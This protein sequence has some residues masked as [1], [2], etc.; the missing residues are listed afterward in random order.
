MQDIAIMSRELNPYCA[1]LRW[2]MNERIFGVDHLVSC[3]A[4]YVAQHC[5]QEFINSL[6]LM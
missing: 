1:A 2:V 6:F 3:I 4:F 5:F